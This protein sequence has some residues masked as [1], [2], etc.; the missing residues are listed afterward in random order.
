MTKEWF[1]FID[2]NE[3]GPY[4]PDDLKRHPRVNPDTLVRKKAW[5]GWLAIRFIK[6]LK[7]IF[8]DKA[9][10]KPV[11]D[12]ALNVDILTDQ[13]ALTISQPDPFHPFLWILLI[14]SLVIYLIYLIS[15]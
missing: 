6:E 4:S 11:K 7:E 2:G 5:K 9:P 15:G 10:K 12:T 1:I 8:K 3:E 14:I 13:A